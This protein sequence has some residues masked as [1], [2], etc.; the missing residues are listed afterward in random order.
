[1]FRD[2]DAE[3]EVRDG[4]NVGDRVMLNLA[5]DLRHDDRVNVAPNPAPPQ[6]T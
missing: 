1:M 3:I 4:V 6:P 5:V 2:L